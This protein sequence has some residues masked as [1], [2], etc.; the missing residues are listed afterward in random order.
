MT[1]VTGV[2]Q[3]RLAS[4]VSR[5]T[6][7]LTT[8]FSY[9]SLPGNLARLQVGL[10]VLL[11]AWVLSAVWSGLW[12]FFPEAQ[13]LPDVDVINPLARSGATGADA[14][15]DPVDIDAIVAAQFF[16]QPGTIVGDGDLA[17]TAGIA[18]V[19]SESEAAVALAG[20]E[21]GAPETRLPLL[22]RGVLAASDAGLG[23]AVI[24]HKRLQDLYQVGAELPVNGEV[25][26]AKVLPDMIVLD[27]AG[28]Y[29][30]LRL[31]EENSVNSGAR[32]PPAPS[33]SARPTAVQGPSRQ[34]AAAAP[35]DA[36]ALAGEYRARLYQDPQSLADVVRISAVREGDALLG[37]RISPGSSTGAFAALGFESG[38]V[39]TAV[40][41]I[42]LTEPSNTVQLYQAMR[43]AREATFELQRKGE[44]VTLDVSI[45]QATGEAR[46]DAPA[47]DAAERVPKSRAESLL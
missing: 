1:A 20:I 41:G 37:Y 29:E 46:D 15:R 32:N 18:G 19:M 38:D 35:E 9:F 10:R 5:V 2:W 25:V 8:L 47:Q 33:R 43:T 31:F 21:D 28:R 26:L 4:S 7:G 34:V 14:M 13:P 40:N 16:G 23:Q 22:L 30:V 6:H 36:A 24:E 42:A 17:E 45:G 39:V 11:I 3:T 44:F 12:S 27:N